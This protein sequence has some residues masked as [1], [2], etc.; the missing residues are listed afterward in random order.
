MALLKLHNNATIFIRLILLSTQRMVNRNLPNQF[1]RTIAASLV[2]CLSIVAGVKAQTPTYIFP[3]SNPTFTGGANSW[4]FSAGTSGGSNMCQW[5][6]LPTDFNT[7]PTGGILITT[8]YIKPASTGSYSYSNMSLKLG[9]TTLTTLPTGTSTWNTG[10]TT[11]Y[12]PTSVTLSTT[13]GNWLAFT[14]STPFY[15]SGGGLLFE[16]THGNTTGIGTGFTVNQ[17]SV[18]GRNGRMYGS[19]ASTTGTA[20][21]ATACFGFDAIPAACSGTPAAGTITN[22]PMNA[23]AP[24]CG[25]SVTLNGTNPGL[26]TGFTYSWQ[27][28]T[29]SATTGFSN[30][31]SGSGATT[32]T[33]TTPPITQTTWFRL[34]ITCTNSSITT[35]SPA[36]QVIA[37]TPQPGTISGR[38]TFCPGDMATYSVPNV[39]GTT[40]SWTLPS[41][42]SGSST[43]NS[44]LATMGSSP[45]SQTISVT[46]TGPCGGPSIAQTLTVLP[47]S[48]PATPTVINGFNSVCSYTTQTYSVTPVAAATSYTW[49]LPNGWT[50]TST[51]P[52]ITVFTDTTSGN[53]TVK[54]VNGCGSS[55]P[56]SLAVGVI[57]SLANPGVITTSSPSGAYCTGMLYNFSINPVPGATSYQWVLP[58]GWSGTTSGTSVQAFAGPAGAG[59]IKVTAYVSCATSPTATLS[60]PVTTTVNPT[61]SITPPPALCG[62]VP[63]TFTAVPLNGGS[64]PTYQWRKNGLNVFSIGNTYT[65]AALS[66]GDVISVRLTSN[67]TCRSTDT[68]NSAALTAN[69]TPAVTPGISINSI[70][71]VTMC[72][73]TTLN[74]T[75]T[76][77]GGGTAPIYQWYVNNLPVATSVNWSSS[78]FNNGDTVTV[79]LTSNAACATVNTVSSNKVGIRVNP[80][81]VPSISITATSTMADGTDITFTAT[82]SGGGTTPAYQW[83]LNGVEIGGETGSSYHSSKLSAGDHVSVRMQSYDPCA[84]PG[85]VTSADVVLKNPLGIAGA[86]W[87]GTLS[88]YPNPTTGRVTVSAGW[89]GTHNAD[90]RVAVEVLNAIGQSIYH[91]EVAPGSAV[92]GEWH[93]DVTLPES[94][95]AGHYILRISAPESGM[96]A[97]LPFVLKR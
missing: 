8:I 57:N 94:A 95:P 58:S 9:N 43:T 77:T 97:A 69:I 3:G 93:Y 16:A 76:M 80:L 84:N 73:G 12:N 59:Q 25:T 46:A 50:G 65:D 52:S 82:Q 27:S 31:S 61:V 88:L 48:A 26:G 92:K 63:A 38:P 60:T 89:T 13:S 44:I 4:P 7:T 56:A 91:S 35:Y 18:T 90:E 72:A 51:G 32:L 5:L 47:G 70:P 64:T 37:G 66:S 87:T 81:V 22:T 21:V 29:T 36:Y 45:S 74:F 10:L 19:N 79:R 15:Y 24:V 96:R 53:V 83:L 86:T 14:L 33:Y 54:A 71:V 42:W 30:V 68:V 6:Y 85:I 34:G 1:F 75:T 17:F 67:A 11:V 55:L 28:S 62:G 2:L 41:G 78:S 39:A 40:Y 23:A 49:T 20:D